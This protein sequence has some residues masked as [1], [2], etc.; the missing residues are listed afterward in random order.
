MQPDI[1][2]HLWNSSL[3]ECGVSTGFS[4]ERANS[5]P[6]TSKLGVNATIIPS[7]NQ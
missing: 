3:V 4:I 6:R 5:T 1:K 7:K 2:A